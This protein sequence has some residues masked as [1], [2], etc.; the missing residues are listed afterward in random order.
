MENQSNN[1]VLRVILLLIFA[2]AVLY[3]CVGCLGCSGR[4]NYNANVVVASNAADGLD[5]KAL[6]GMIKDVK[7]AED[8][9]KKL[10]SPGSI[11][12]LDLNEDDKV[13]YIKVTEY[14][15]KDAGAWGFSLTVEPEQGEVQEIA[16]I[17]IEKNGDK[18]EVE[19]RG[20]E[21]IYG[22]NQYYHTDHF[23]RNMLIASYLTRGFGM[24]SSPYHYG[25]YPSYYHSYRTIPRSSYVSTTRSYTKGSSI[26]K[27][28]SSRSKISSKNPN[29]GRSASK[30]I[31]AGLKNPTTTQKSFQKRNPSKKV[32]KGGFG[33]RS[34]RSVR[35]SSRSRS[36]SSFGK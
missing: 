11:N 17:D 23:W 31:T 5:L 30:G 20:N 25:Y 21:N 10:N 4:E 12:N 16:S 9:E 28:K 34:S 2:F 19:V 15:D 22:R 24:W 14:G 36:S 8:L 35:S 33:R 6:T 7:S 27:A 13:D 26:S 18:G 1:T 32:G 29:R 3:G